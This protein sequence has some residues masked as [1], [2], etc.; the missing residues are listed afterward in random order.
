VSTATRTWNDSTFGPGDARTGNFAPDCDMRNL[1]A[2]GECG[3]ASNLAFGQI[4]V[5]AATLAD[6]ARTGWGV[7]QYNYQTSVQLQHELRPGLAVN[8]GYFRTW[9]ANHTVTANTALTPADFTPYCLPAPTDSRLGD[10]SAQQV[11]GLFDLNFDRKAVV[12]ANVIR[13]AKNLGAGTPTE[14]YNGVDL[15]VSG[16]WGRGAFA[17]GGVSLGRQTLDFCYAN[18]HPELT[19]ASF[20]AN[21]PRSSNYCE[22]VPSWS[23]G[24][25][26]KGQVAYPLPLGLQ[27][28]GTW[29]DVPGLPL[30][31]AYSVTNA[32]VA[33]FLGRNLSACA[34]PTGACTATTTIQLLAGAQAGDDGARAAKVFDQRVREVDLRLTK[35][36]RFGPRRRV[37]GIFDLY[38]VFNNRPPQASNGNYSPAPAVNGGSW[39]QVQSLLTGRLAKFGAQIDW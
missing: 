37:Q 28:S 22:I 19:P 29:K 36:F 24:S 32:Q 9:W 30:T 17:S 23:D 15:S 7:R 12:P 20:P 34:A 13:L 38:N 14:I 2:N 21:Y 1:Q 18:G 39:E 6:E 10:V 16:R 3:I 33:P 27:I 35:S 11:C 26:L 31:A 4:A 5:P 25:Q 8:V